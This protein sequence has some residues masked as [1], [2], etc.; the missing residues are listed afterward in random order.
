MGLPYGQRSRLVT[1]RDTPCGQCPAH[2]SKA[3]AVVFHAFTAHSCSPD[4]DSGF[5]CQCLPRASSLNAATRGLKNFNWCFSWTRRSAASGTT[6]KVCW[7]WQQRRGARPEGCSQHISFSHGRC[8]ASDM[9]GGGGVRLPGGPGGLPHQDSLNGALSE[10][11]TF[12]LRIAFASLEPSCAPW[13]RTDCLIPVLRFDGTA[14][15]SPLPPP[16]PP[17]PS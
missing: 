15:T 14:P 11:R 12:A 1:N 9:I 10:P 5:T 17:P 4:D 8:P 7:C 16:L 2:C 3:A 6:R 13:T